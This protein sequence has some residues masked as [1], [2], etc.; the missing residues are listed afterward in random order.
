MARI[1]KISLT[2]CLLF[3]VG[4]RAGNVKPEYLVV[5][6]NNKLILGMAEA[7]SIQNGWEFRF[8]ELYSIRTVNVYYDGDL[9]NLILY[10]KT[11]KGWKETEVL[12]IQNSYP[13]LVKVNEKTDSIR[14]LPK[15]SGKGRILLCEF[16]I[17]S[18]QSFFSIPLEKPPF[19]K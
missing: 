14:I 11:D 12:N 18:K 5:E 9:V 10:C 4:C 2:L 1:V 3:L 6:D 13:C 16:R 7:T 19:I 8:P 15:F 17:S